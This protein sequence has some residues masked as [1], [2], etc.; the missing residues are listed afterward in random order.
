[1][2]GLLP[3]CAGVIVVG[4]LFQSGWTADEPPPVAN[5]RLQVLDLIFTVEDLGGTVVD[6]Q[7]KETDSE[8]RIELAADV[9]FDFDKADIRKDARKTLQQAAA[10]IKEKA[11]GTVRI[12]GHTDGKGS[13]AYNQKLSQRRADSVKDWF[14]KKEGLGNVRFSTPGS[15]PGNR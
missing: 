4:L 15:A 8:I 12:E 3:V 10:F 14:V 13:D 6:L 5:P 2:K 11:K 1:M 7:V 9:L